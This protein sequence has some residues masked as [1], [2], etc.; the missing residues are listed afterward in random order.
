MLSRLR[1][2]RVVSICSVTVLQILVLLVPPFRVFWVAFYAVS[3][4]STS[5][6]P[7]V[8]HLGDCDESDRAL[9]LRLV[10]VSGIRLP[11]LLRGSPWWGAGCHNICI[12]FVML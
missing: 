4:V 5:L 2:P 12:F 1:S 6:W 8:H 3:Q 10:G 9:C 11:P 7:G